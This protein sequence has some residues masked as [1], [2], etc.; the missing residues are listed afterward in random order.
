MQMDLG[1]K[2]ESEPTPWNRVVRL[3]ASKRAGMGT[4]F[5][6][7]QQVSRLRRPYEAISSLDSIACRLT[8]FRLL[9][10]SNCRVCSPGSFRYAIG[11]ET[12]TL[13]S[14]STPCSSGLAA[15]SS[16]EPISLQKALTDNSTPR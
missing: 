6:M 7:R 4:S 9:A 13:L 15:L 5:A 12:P 14:A 10:A 3:E 8:R 16:S 1:A 11:V 2:G